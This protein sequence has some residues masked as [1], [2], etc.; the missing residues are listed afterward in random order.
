MSNTPLGL[1]WPNPTTQVGLRPSP[2]WFVGL[3]DNLTS[4]FSFFFIYMSWTQSSLVVQDVR[5]VH[6]YHTP[7]PITLP[8]L[9]NVSSRTW[10]NV[11]Y[12]QN[13]RCLFQ[14]DKKTN[15][16]VVMLLPLVADEGFDKR[17]KEK[18]ET[19][20]DGGVCWWLLE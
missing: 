3:V 20:G 10:V 1:G 17:E 9:E 13:K 6:L 18:R 12:A 16:L 19:M 5:P 2:T 14:K 8:L 11:L 15:L 4:F 7:N